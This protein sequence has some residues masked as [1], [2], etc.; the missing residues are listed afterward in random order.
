MTEDII[1]STDETGAQHDDR[2]AD[3]TDA[4]TL[5]RRAA[6]AGLGVAGLF[7]LGTGTASADPQGQVGTASDPLTKLYADAVDA[8][9]VTADAVQLGDG[10]AGAPSLAFSGE[11][12]TGL[13]RPGSGMLGL[14]ANGTDGL[15]VDAARREVNAHNNDIVN[16]SRISGFSLETDEL[17]GR[18]S[19]LRI[20]ADIEAAGRSL[21]GLSEL[22]VDRVRSGGGGLSLSSNG[23][24]ALLLAGPDQVVGSGQGSDQPTPNLVGGHATNNTDGQKLLGA[25]I[26]G[27]GRDGNANVVSSDYATVGGGEGNAASGVGATV[28]GGE[29]NT[30]SGDHSFAAGRYAEAADS[31]AF[32]WNDGSG[33]SSSTGSDSDQFSSS[34]S[35]TS[36]AGEPV[37]ISTATI[38]AS[39]GVRFVTGDDTTTADYAPDYAWI[40]RSGDVRASGG[41]DADGSVKA[42]KEV[43]AGDYVS[44]PKLYTTDIAP[45]SGTA[46][47]GVQPDGQLVNMSSSSVR[48]KTNVEPLSTETTDVLDLEPRSFEYE[49]TG[50]ADVGFLAE[51]VDDA[52][53][54]LVLYDDEGRPD[55]V[56]YRRLGVYLL[57]EIR[58]NRERLDDH[59]DGLDDATDQID[60][61]R[62]ENDL[63]RERIDELEAENE[64][65]RERLGA[66]EERLGMDDPAGRQGVADD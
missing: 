30:A 56:K 4:S 54:D 33:G 39:E 10:S 21:Y 14:A 37:G 12:D 44:G 62:A 5:S 31:N 45:G 25:T 15:T 29:S 9:D 63:L 1:E 24:R 53:S 59:G 36:E 43:V 16:A 19:M 7:G 27:G 66:I 17:R 40:S 6:L 65:L 32:V 61:I 51:E 13:Y 49:A 28:P 11:T 18:S 58:R 26:A 57:P 20:S 42:G 46:D 22:D 3:A 50:E 60:D 55:G 64:Q 34:T 38:K 41:V 2:N 47:V 23:R 8:G 52:V 35:V 48:Y